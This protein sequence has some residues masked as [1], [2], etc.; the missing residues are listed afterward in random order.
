MTQLRRGGFGRVVL[1]GA[2]LALTGAV[3]QADDS[4]AIRILSN[5]ADLI[6]G[7][8][9]L[10][11][12]ELTAAAD[13]SSLRVT[14]DGR[15]VTA[16]FSL[17]ADGR[18]TGLLSGLADGENLLQARIDGAGAQITITNHPLHGPVFAGPQVLPWFCDTVAAG[19]GESVAPYCEAEKVYTYN[20]KPKTCAPL[21][22]PSIDT[23]GIAANCLLPEY[24][25]ENPPTDV[26]T[27]TTDQGKTVPFIVRT[28]TGVIDRGI[29][30]I[31]ALYDPT[32]PD[33]APWA[34]QDGYNG[35]V[36]M[37]FG[38]DCNPRHGQGQP[39]SVLD[40]PALSRGFAVMTSNLNILGHNCND[41]VSAESMMMLKEHFIENYGEIRYV[42]GNGASGGSIQ[43][44]WMVSNYPGLLDG[45][46]PAASFPDMWQ[47]IFAAQDCHLLNRV[48]N[49]LSPTLWPIVTQRAVVSGF[50]T[51]VTCTLFDNPTGQFSYAQ[52]S[53]KPDLA[54]NCIGGLI[55]SLAVSGPAA[56][57]S[58]VYNASTN[59]AGVRCTVQDYG[60]SIWGKRASDGFANRPYDNVGIQYGLRALEDGMISV[61]QFVDLNEKIGGIDIDWNYQSQRSEADP[62][63]LRVAYRGGR[64]NNPHEA[65]KVPIV[66]LRGFSPTEIH[67]DVHSYSMRA[68]LDQVNG[69]HD[70]QIIWNGGVAVFPDP[71]SFAESFLMM[72]QWLAAIE[73][74]TSDDARAVKVLRHKPAEAVDACWIAG[75]KITDMS[76]CDAAFPYFGTPRIAASGPL[77]DDIIKCALTPL[78]R[79]RYG[80]TFSDAQWQRMLATFVTGVCDYSQSAQGYEPSV[81]WLGYAKGPGGEPLGNAPVSQAIGSGSGPGSEDAGRF[82]GAMNPLLA[83]GLMLILLMRRTVK[84]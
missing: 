44:H 49:T 37:T 24:D 18:V 82:G 53:M 20:Y 52:I 30:R 11:A 8:N 80:V 81:P 75:Q 78:D 45:I 33:Y 57:T 84:A 15:D 68:R 36:L 14:V 5:R 51:P 64:I 28:E 39:I 38:G 50:A 43:Q 76:L 2:L 17:R 6:S 16:D 55:A 29:Y 19:L 61:E 48:F 23:G 69:H 62:E 74:D 42:I 26:D 32:Q 25:P 34:P 13:L 72:D 83:L 10:V 35:K 79:A 22:F 3:V 46:Q 67:T 58:Y 59:P 21:V 40:V 1:C 7:G 77:A 71:V 65:A 27:T 63:A 60:A 54:Q 70:N 4:I 66:D 56:D 12:I 31:A 41:V 47:V 9:A 73:A